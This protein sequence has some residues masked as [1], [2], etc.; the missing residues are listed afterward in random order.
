MNNAI[1]ESLLL[2][3]MRKVIELNKL[4]NYDFFFN[5]NGGT[6]TIEIYYYKDKILKI[7]WLNDFV[8]TKINEKNLQVILGNLQKFE[9]LVIND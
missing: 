1:C 4:E 3:I 9:E 5:L 6:N 2:Q 7:N 8:L